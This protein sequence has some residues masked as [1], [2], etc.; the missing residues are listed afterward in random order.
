MDTS[1]L[2]RPTTPPQRTPRAVRAGV[3]YVRHHDELLV[4]LI[5]MALIGTLAY[6]FQ[7]TIPLLAH[8]TFH[9]GATGFGL[10]YAAMGFGSVVAGLTVAGRAAPRIRTTTQAAAV[11]GLGLALAAIA[12]SPLTAALCLSAAGAASVVYSSTTNATLQL[13]ADPA[14]RGRVVALYIVAFMGSTPIG[15][16]LVGVV[17]QLAGARASLAIGALGCFAAVAL[18][19]IFGLRAGDASQYA[20]VR[21][22]LRLG[23]RTAPSTQSVE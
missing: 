1:R 4:P 3:T 22:S 21:P 6:E 18:A 5:M 15:G 19:V 23:R 14:M 11:F 9:L 13:R 16:P 7:V 8:D 20:G 10:L 17:G 2:Y 12:P